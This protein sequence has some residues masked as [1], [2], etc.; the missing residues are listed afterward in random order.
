M[1]YRGV[2]PRYTFAVPSDIW[3]PSDLEL[4]MMT[5][6]SPVDNHVS[7]ALVS[8]GQ[9]TQDRSAQNQVEVDSYDADIAKQGMSSLMRR[10]LEH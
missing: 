3:R 6:V 8:V 10:E 1:R 9:I 2:E 5:T 4:S 7:A